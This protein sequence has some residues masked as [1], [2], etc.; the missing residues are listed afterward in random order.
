M[1]GNPFKS[2]IDDYSG[3]MYQKAVKTG[4]ETVESCAIADPPSSESLAEWINIWER[5]TNLEKG[6]WDMGLETL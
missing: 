6:F 1:E 4:L 3:E 2:W 5:C